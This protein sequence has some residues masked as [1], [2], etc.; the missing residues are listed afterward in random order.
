MW[1][2]QGELM[3]KFGKRGIACPCVRAGA[4]GGPSFEQRSAARNVRNGAHRW[5]MI[6]FNRSSGGRSA[7][8]TARVPPDLPNTNAS[9]M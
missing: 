5:V 8:E 2:C 4:S 1:R 6:R 9:N 3:S 7:S